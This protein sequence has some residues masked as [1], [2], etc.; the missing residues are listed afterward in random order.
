MH[1]QFYLT[2]YRYYDNVKLETFI[3]PSVNDLCTN[4]GIYST[5]WISAAQDD[6][7]YPPTVDE[8]K[9]LLIG[10]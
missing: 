10:S 1:F 4:T 2:C 5:T 7:Q 3:V 8:C 9:F 6:I